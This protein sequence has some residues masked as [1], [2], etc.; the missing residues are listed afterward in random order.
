MTSFSNEKKKRH[1]GLGAK[2]K[3]ARH[4]KW[5]TYSWNTDT[6]TNPLLKTLEVKV[7]SVTT[8]AWEEIKSQGEVYLSASS[9][10]KLTLGKEADW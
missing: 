5:P 8:L 4:W 10:K 1:W 3:K 7:R 6:K 2:N 9:E